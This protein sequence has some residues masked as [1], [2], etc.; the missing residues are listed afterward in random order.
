MSIIIPD[1]SGIS[2]GITGA[3]NILGQALMARQEQKKEEQKTQ[4]QQ[5]RFDALQKTLDDVDIMTPEGQKSFLQS[6][7]QIGAPNE[8]LDILKSQTALQR[9][10]QTSSFNIDDPTELAGLFER[11]GV[12][13][14]QANDWADLYGNLSQG[15]RTQFAQMLIDKMQR[16]E[17]GKPEEVAEI[18]EGVSE[19]EPP[20]EYPEVNLFE[21]LTPKERV[22]REKELFAANREEFGENRDKLRALEQERNKLNRS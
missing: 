14:E 21:G 13:P 4:Q 15:G 6:A 8:A 17:F 20:Y 22:Q 16:G 1:L 12:P 11:L 7:L 9:A 3:S 18:I 10:L 5:A 19:E 2:Q